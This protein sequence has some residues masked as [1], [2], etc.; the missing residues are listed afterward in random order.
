[1]KIDEI[2]ARQRPEALQESARQGRTEGANVFESI[3]DQAIGATATTPAKSQKVSES[4]EIPKS[5]EV[6]SSLPLPGFSR[7]EDH[8]LERNL[9]NRLQ[10]VQALLDSAEGNPKK[11]ES[12]IELL[13]KE[14]ESLKSEL[15]GLASTDPLKTVADEFEVLAYVESIKWKRGDYL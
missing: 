15:G 11:V 9:E 12:V 1:M 4:G 3:L 10:Q 6:L 8:G 13:V 7:I 14:S 2:I 5:N